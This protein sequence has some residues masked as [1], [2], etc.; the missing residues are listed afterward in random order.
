L[1]ILKIVPIFTA[2]ISSFI[3]YLIAKDKSKKQ[4]E[5]FFT[6]KIQEIFVEQQEEIRALKEEVRK[7][8]N[9]NHEL[10]LEIIKLKE[11]LIKFEVE[12]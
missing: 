11:Q 5:Q 2:I 10:R 12:G 4:L 7:L 3:T 8:T 1:D 6:S 9:E